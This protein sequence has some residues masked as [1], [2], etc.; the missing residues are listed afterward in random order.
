MKKGIDIKVRDVLENSL[1]AYSVLEFCVKD[2]NKGV[3]MSNLLDR[4]L[5]SVIFSKINWMKSLDHGISWSSVYNSTKDSKADVLTV[6]SAILSQYSISKEKTGKDIAGVVKGSKPTTTLEG[7]VKVAKEEILEKAKRLYKKGVVYRPFKGPESK[8]TSISSGIIKSNGRGDIWV[9]GQ[10]GFI[11][12]DGVWS[13]IVDNPEKDIEALI[14]DINLDKAR[15][16]YGKG[17]LYRPVRGFSGMEGVTVESNGD[18]RSNS[19]GDIWTYNQKGFIHSNGK[20]GVLLGD[21]GVTVQGNPFEGLYKGSDKSF[22]KTPSTTTPTT[23]NYKGIETSDVKLKK[24]RK[25]KLKY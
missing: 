8:F 19:K 24:I 12:K 15:K 18:I 21:K 9:G 2:T 5:S 7:L 13:D 11:Y 22:I 25:S 14:L 4:P 3:D 6:I 10:K 20:W 16:I 17:V 1:I 23:V